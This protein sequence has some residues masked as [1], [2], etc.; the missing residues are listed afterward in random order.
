MTPDA[1]IWGPR[2]VFAGYPEISEKIEGFHKNWPECRLVLETGLNTFLNAARLGAAIIG[3]DGA[4]L[5]SGQA[6]IELAD[7]GRIQ[8]VI[9]FWEP[10]P[11][12][13]ADW[14][15]H[16]APGYTSRAPSAG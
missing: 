7:D 3:N 16:L 10:L 15:A 2:R 4:V 6:V 1:Q 5:A 14:P 9:P 11:S 12:L 8:R 13:P